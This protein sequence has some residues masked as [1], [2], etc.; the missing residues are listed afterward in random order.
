[1]TRTAHLPLAA[2]AAAATL[3]GCGGAD[4]TSPNTP[5]PTTN[6]HRLTV[7]YVTDENGGRYLCAV[8][9]TNLGAAISC[10]WNTTR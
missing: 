8:Y 7:E 2:I 1:M 3:T 4:T 10:D 9:R 6:N 5:T